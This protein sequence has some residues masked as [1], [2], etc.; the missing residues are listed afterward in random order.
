MWSFT[1]VQILK[2]ILKQFINARCSPHN[3]VLRSYF[4]KTFLF[5]MFENEDTGFWRSDNLRGCINYLIVE[6]SK[7]IRNGELRHYFFSR[8]NL[9]SMKLTKEAQKEL[10]EILETAIQC[11][12]GTFKECKSLCKA[13]TQFTTTPDDINT[14]TKQAKENKLVRNDKCMMRRVLAAYCNMIRSEICLSSVRGWIGNITTQLDIVNYKTPLILLVLTKYLSHNLFVSQRYSDNRS[15]YKLHRLA[16]SKMSFD[17][18][19]CKLWYALILVGKGDYQSCLTVVNEVLSRI[20]PYA[21]HCNADD[22]N[23]AKTLHGGKYFD[24]TKDI[25]TRAWNAWLF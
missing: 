17:I 3:R 25:Y 7:F 16:H 9:L 12:V 24:S 20:P 15:V 2:I 11:D 6:F 10:L 22:D 1:H 4:I 8:F 13:W 19:T 21:L 18:S 5:W 14:V 23:A